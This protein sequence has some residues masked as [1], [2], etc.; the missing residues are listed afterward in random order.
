[1]CLHL[2]TLCAA[3][4]ELKVN[5]FLNQLKF[6]NDLIEYSDRKQLHNAQWFVKENFLKLKSLKRGSTEAKSVKI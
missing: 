5:R 1:M 6:V 3:K 2:L 4:L